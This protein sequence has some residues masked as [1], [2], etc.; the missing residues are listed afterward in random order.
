MRIHEP[1]QIV[2]EISHRMRIVNKSRP[3][4]IMIQFLLKSDRQRVWEARR[5]LKGTNISLNEDFPEAYNVSRSQL[6]PVV[7]AAKAARMKATLVIQCSD[8]PKS[9]PGQLNDG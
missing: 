2:I 3:R 7:Q 4:P 5:N 9:N 1:Q 6:L 8:G